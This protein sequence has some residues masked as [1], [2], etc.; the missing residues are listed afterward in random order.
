MSKRTPNPDLPHMINLVMGDWSGDGH[1]K[2]E[3]VTIL[4]NIDKR[5]LEK[6]YKAGAKKTGVDFENEV[7]EEYEDNTISAE[8]VEKLAKHGFKIEDY[9]EDEDPSD[10]TYGLWTDGYSLAWLFVAQVGNP[11]FKYEVITDDSPNINIGGYGLL[12]S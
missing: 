10:G 1:S 5:A 12:G 7:A 2:T 8:V 11:N 9:S 6:A 4:S 3:T